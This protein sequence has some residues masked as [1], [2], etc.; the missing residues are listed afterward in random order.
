[1][2]TG[3]PPYSAQSE[4]DEWVYISSARLS[5]DSCGEWVYPRR[6]ADAKRGSFAFPP[7]CQ[8]CGAKVNV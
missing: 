4:P 7:E 6:R 1:M 8:A 3:P 2:R 5:C